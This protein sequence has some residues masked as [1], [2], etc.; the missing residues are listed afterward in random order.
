[1]AKKRPLAWPVLLIEDTQA[2]RTLGQDIP[3]LSLV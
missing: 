1:M 2:V 3:Q